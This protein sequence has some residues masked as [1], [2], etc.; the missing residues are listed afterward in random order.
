MTFGAEPRLNLAFSGIT[1]FLRAPICTDLD[2]LDADMAILGIPFD[3]GTTWMP[4]SRLGPRRIREMAMR[5]ASQGASAGYFDLDDGRRY[6]QREMQT[7]RIVDCGDVDILYTN[8]EGTFANATRAVEAIVSRGAMPI[9]I[10]GDHAVT[11]PVVRAFDQPM[12]VIHFDA[13]I[14]YSPFIHGV[15]MQRVSG[16]TSTSAAARRMSRAG[17]GIGCTTKTRGRL[18]WSAPR[19]RL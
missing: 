19:V 2:Q 3:E 6:L 14:D 12:Q 7:G 17:S 16:K 10:G 11:F 8:P 1:T 15:I 4:G 9:V 18:I 5:F 13:H